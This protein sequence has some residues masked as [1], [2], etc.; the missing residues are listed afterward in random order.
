[1]TVVSQF[2]GQRPRL[3]L[4]GH[5]FWTSAVL[6]LP[7]LTQARS[8]QYLSPKVTLTGQFRPSVSTGAMGHLPTYSRLQP[9]Q[10]LTHTIEPG[11]SS[12]QQRERPAAAPPGTSQPYHSP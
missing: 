8:L 2:S 5:R 3:L 1:M 7:L 4:I 12:S 9:H 11:P 10:P 6:P